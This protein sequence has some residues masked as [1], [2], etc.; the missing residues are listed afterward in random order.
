MSRPPHSANFAATLEAEPHVDQ[1]QSTFAPAIKFPSL[2]NLR[3]QM[4]VLLAAVVV[5]YANSLFNGFTLDDELY[6]LRNPQ[7]TQHSLRLLFSPNA[8]SNVF[9]PVT[10][11]TLALNWMAA[12]YKPLG[13]HLLNLL[14]HAAVVLLVFFV[15]RNI[16]EAT[17]FGELASFAAALLFAVHPIHTEAVSSI[18]GRSELLA[19]G[20]LLAAWLLHLHDRYVLALLAFALALL[21]KESAVGLP[22]LVLAGDYAKGQLKSWLRYVAFGAVTVLYVA[23]LWRMQ[24]GHF[25]AANVSLLDN[26]LVLLPPGLRVLNAIRIAWKYI[27]LLIFPATLSCDYSYNQIPLYADTRHLLAPALGL[28]LA[29]ALWAWAIW[30]REPG[31]LLAGAIYIAGFAAASN[32]L[33]RTGTIFGERLA[34]FPSMGFCLL[35]VLIW[36]EL[37][38]RNRRAAFVLLAVALLALGVRTV[39]RNRDWH[40]NASLYISAGDAVPNSAKMRAFR[41]IVYLGRNDFTR[42]RSELETAL[43]IYPDYPDAVEGLGLLEAR[44][45]NDSAALPILKKA[46][47]M[48]DPKDFDYDYRAVNVASLEIKMGQLDDALKLLDREIAQSPNYA[49]SW[50]NRAVLHL[51][52][53]EFAEAR[54]DAQTALRLD[55]SNAQARN[56]LERPAGA[57]LP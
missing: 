26:P 52:L 23:L 24:G 6:I 42:C 36:L 39:V 21:S 14:L 38:R 7:V 34:Y 46:L 4:G 31:Y 22:A 13:Y 11:A 15:L 10:F 30:K 19:A 40:D 32:V 8:A 48:S 57:P 45:G 47:D 53:R 25:G 50:S 2:F 9:R 20:F 16:L 54:S 33:A 44:S 12:G 43:K 1:P 29:I 5:F 27:A 18:V 49:R 56:V 41:G 28:V 51:K 3:L 17:A 55:P 37:E 35:S